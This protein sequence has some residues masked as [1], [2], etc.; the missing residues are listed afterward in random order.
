MPIA[1][2]ALGSGLHDPVE[3]CW[4]DGPAAPA[5]LGVARRAAGSLRVGAG[6]SP[7][8]EG[9]AW[10]LAGLDRFAFWSPFAAVDLQRCVEREAIPA[11]DGGPRWRRARLWARAADAARGPLPLPPAR[12][13]VDVVG[14][15]RDVPDA[16]VEI[17]VELLAGEP[18][19]LPRRRVQLLELAR[20]SAV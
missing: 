16:V 17:G 18:G 3:V 10:V 19:A 12:T 14:M 13:I 2:H 7:S 11:P 20:A 1:V 5:V 9:L 15:V 8:T 6:R 4:T